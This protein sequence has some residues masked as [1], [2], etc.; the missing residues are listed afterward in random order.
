MLT[1]IAPPWTDEQVRALNQYQSDGWFHPFTCANNAVNDHRNHPV[2][3]ATTVGFVCDACGYTQD[4]AWLFM[5]EPCP[6]FFATK[7]ARVNTSI[8][9]NDAPRDQTAKPF[10]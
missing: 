10:S 9:G 7:I 2:L 8:R 5:T 1:K 4:W 3:R 6:D